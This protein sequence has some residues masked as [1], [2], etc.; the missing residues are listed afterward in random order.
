M[1]IYEN[2]DHLF[3]LSSP[4]EFVDMDANVYGRDT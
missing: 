4:A 2:G 3:F 1:M